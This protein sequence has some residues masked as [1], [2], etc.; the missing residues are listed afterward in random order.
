MAAI[1]EAIEDDQ[2]SE[3]G[4]ARAISLRRMTA[5]TRFQVFGEHLAGAGE[6]HQP[7][8][9]LFFHGRV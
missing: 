8:A 2:S 4:M 6:F 1:D 7:A 9:W 3:A 5:F